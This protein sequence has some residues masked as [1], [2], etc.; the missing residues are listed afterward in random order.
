MKYCILLIMTMLSSPPDSV[1]VAFWNMENFFDPFV[2]S[3]LT[4]N[5]YTENGGQHWNSSR[6][7]RKRNNL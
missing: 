7:Y 6:F 2:D 3:T 5:E 1:M 4:Y